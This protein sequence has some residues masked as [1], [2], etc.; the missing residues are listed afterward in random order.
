MGN[1]VLFLDAWNRLI[2][3]CATMIYIIQIV[4]QNGIF[5]LHYLTILKR[6]NKTEIRKILQKV[7]NND[8]FSK[9][10]FMKLYLGRLVATLVW[11]SSLTFLGLQW[12]I[13]RIIC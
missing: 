3:F 12:G 5:N 1:E 13:E 6:E 7:Q 4:F 2:L 10:G 9:L 8:H 11:P